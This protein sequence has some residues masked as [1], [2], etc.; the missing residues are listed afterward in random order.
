MRDIYANEFIKY[1]KIDGVNLPVLKI[2]FSGDFDEGLTKVRSECAF[3][4]I[5]MHDYKRA[6]YI[7]Q[8]HFGYQ[9]AIYGCYGFNIKENKNDRAFYLK[10]FNEYKTFKIKFDGESAT[11]YSYYND[12]KGD[13]LNRMNR[14]WYDND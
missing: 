1:I 14:T 7:E 3:Q 4:D 9:Y 13:Q 11:D 2:T 12:P 8:D 6:L 5:R 10:Q